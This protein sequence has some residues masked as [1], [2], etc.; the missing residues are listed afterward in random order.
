MRIKQYL[1]GLGVGIIVAA[2]LMG[3]A[4]KNSAT[5][6]DDEI[7]A[8]AKELGMVEQKTLSDIS[9]TPTPTEIPEEKITPA[10]TE[11]PMTTVEPLPSESPMETA[12]P[13][14]FEEPERTPEVIVE[15]ITVTLEIQKGDSSDVVCRKL[16]ELGVIEN[17][18][19]YNRYLCDNDYDKKLNIGT[20]KLSIGMTDE[21]IAKII[22]RTR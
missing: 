1:K 18:T 13:T 16:K 5:M 19:V 12:S 20:Y 7:K 21:E 4:T 15:E 14:P 2:L 22:T 6:T 11:P 9:K 17:P 3:I 10:P 8:R